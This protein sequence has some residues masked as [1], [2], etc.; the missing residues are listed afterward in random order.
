MQ[1]LLTPLDETS[2]QK[3]E[4]LDANFVHHFF[5]KV[6]L[7]RDLMNKLVML[8]LKWIYYTLIF[9]II[10]KIMCEEN[11]WWNMIFSIFFMNP[12]F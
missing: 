8:L 7:D 5:L 6:L 3:F 4:C 10:L 2:S 11:F 9:I 12:L 1:R